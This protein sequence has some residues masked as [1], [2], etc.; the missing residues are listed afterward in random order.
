MERSRV[1]A[2]R[3]LRIGTAGWSLPRGVASFFPPSGSHLQRY[4]AVF[5]AVEINSSF[6]RSHRRETYARWA[7]TVP[8]GFRFSV[9]LAREI[10]HD[11][12]LRACASPLRKFLGEIEGLGARLGCVLIQLPPSF[13]FER[14]PVTRFLTLLRRHFDGNAVVEP[15]HATW[16]E[17]AVEDTLRAF[18]IG[19]AGSDPALCA[20]AA[21]PMASR[22]VA[23]RRLHGSPRMYY[24]S[25]D[26]A[27][28][29]AVAAD[30]AAHGSRTRDGWCIFDN[31]AHGHATAN[32][33]RLVE[34][35][36]ARA[37]S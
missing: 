9:K 22:R 11:L 35:T 16:F 21:T 34:L 36:G 6:Y 8:S 28:L 26:E 2:Q 25:Y 18:D 33:L 1:S 4:A 13:A 30:L 32:A 14:A 20:D 3:T 5:N 17:P 37:M 10:T 7:A 23:Y 29:E 24:S 27:F 31:T 12:R 19:R 15:R